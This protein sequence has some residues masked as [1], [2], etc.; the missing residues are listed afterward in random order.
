[1]MT[2]ELSVEEAIKILKGAIKKPNTKD[3]YLRQ[4]ID[5]AIKALEQTRWIPIKWHEI[6]D[7]ERVIEEYPNEWLV[8]FECQMPDDGERILVQ[9]KW[10]D[11][12]LDECYIDDGISLDSGRDWID[13]IV[14][15]KP[16]PEPYKEE[17]NETDN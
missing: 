2:N 14:A 6:T 17:N 4:A 13:D 11:I 3:G 7:E 10:G 5:M 16:L 1:M 15:W 9:I 8:L 12:E